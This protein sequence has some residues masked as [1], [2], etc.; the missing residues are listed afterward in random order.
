MKR[1]KTLQKWASFELSSL[2]P[3]IL[4]AWTLWNSTANLQ[5]FLDLIHILVKRWS[6]I[7][8]WKRILFFH[9]SLQ[10]LIFP[11]STVFKN[12]INKIYSL[13]LRV[14]S[15]DIPE[16]SVTRWLVLV[17]LMWFSND[18]FAF[19]SCTSVGLCRTLV[20]GTWMLISCFAPSAD[21]QQAL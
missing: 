19:S 18:V 21:G 17:S 2:L 16:I 5:G 1:W 12:Q 13:Y 14:F 20:E 9:M 6:N 8:G 11:D 7:T 4:E 10:C 3:T 15:P